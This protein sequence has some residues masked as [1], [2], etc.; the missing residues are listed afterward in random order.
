MWLI[1]SWL[2]MNQNPNYTLY[3]VTDETAYHWSL[4]TLPSDGTSCLNLKPPFSLA[5]FKDIFLVQ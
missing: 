2:A 5:T 4:A 3:K 1:S